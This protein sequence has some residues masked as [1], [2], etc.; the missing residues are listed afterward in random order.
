MTSRQL[1][2]DTLEGCNHTGRVPRQIWFLPWAG[3]HYPRQALQLR[4]DF[5]DDILAAPVCYGDA[6]RTVGNPYAAGYYIDEWGCRFE[7]IQPGVIGEVKAPILAGEDGWQQAGRVHL[8]VEWLTFDRDAVNAFCAG[9]D[10]FI[11][12]GACP[13]YL[14]NAFMA[15]ARRIAPEV[16]RES[17]GK[18]HLPAGG[19]RESIGYAL[20]AG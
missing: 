16:V 20:I 13:T 8:P 9:K 1:V 17:T 19:R 14:C 18:Y 5:P 11:T 12:A 3:F 4:R 2:W 15:C 10:R 6:P 7:N